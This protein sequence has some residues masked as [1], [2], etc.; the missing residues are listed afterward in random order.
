MC[1]LARYKV[2]ESSLDEYGE[3]IHTETKQYQKRYV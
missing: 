2:S 1:L 3:A